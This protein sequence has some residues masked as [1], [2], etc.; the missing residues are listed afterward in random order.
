MILADARRPQVAG[1][2]LRQYSLFKAPT[3]TLNTP[4]RKSKS[5][6]S[7]TR[8][9]MCLPLTSPHLRIGQGQC[10]MMPAT[11]QVSRIVHWQDAARGICA[12]ELP[13]AA[14]APAQAIV[15]GR[16]GGQR[17]QAQLQVVGAAHHVVH[18][19][20]LCVSWHHFQARFRRRIWDSS[21]RTP[22]ARLLSPPRILVAAQAPG[23]H[24][25]ADAC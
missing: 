22:V 13:L 9:S 10:I 16:D 1:A 12:N 7:P 21:G 15:D 2:Q 5:T 17:L 23:V 6:M 11:E 25:T 19:A 18:D 20:H 3:L 4:A 8:S 24:E 14:D